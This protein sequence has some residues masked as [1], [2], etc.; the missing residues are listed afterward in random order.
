MVKMR[1]KQAKK[2]RLNRQ[3]R[4]DLEGFSVADRKNEKK[5]VEINRK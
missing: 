5:W 2:H 4:M 1:Q 3:S